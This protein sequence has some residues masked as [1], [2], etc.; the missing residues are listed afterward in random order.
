M[1]GMDFS[2]AFCLFVYLLILMALIYNVVIYLVK[3]G[4]YKVF[5]VSVFYASSIAVIVARMVYFSAILYQFYSSPL[6]R[7]FE[8][9]N[10]SFFV[11]TYFKIIMGFY[12]A[13]SMIELGLRVKA[14]VDLDP[15]RAQRNVS[16]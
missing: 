13:A 16:C 4:R 1:I 3:Q 8:L 2:I 15:D 7:M 10:N 9:I 12:Q 11:S 5:L 6:V 14:S